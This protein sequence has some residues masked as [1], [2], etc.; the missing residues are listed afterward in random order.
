MHT[1]VYK[2]FQVCSWALLTYEE[3]VLEAGHSSELSSQMR[4]IKINNASHFF[5]QL[6]NARDVFLFSFCSGLVS[7]LARP[8][9]HVFETY[10]SFSST[11][12]MKNM[13]ANRSGSFLEEQKTQR[14]R[15]EKQKRRKH[16][17]GLQRV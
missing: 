11:S 6:C 2:T 14:L 7:V 9:K 4:L 13:H 3:A 1:Y 16:V 5:K 10:M 15:L 12:C 8:L 17:N